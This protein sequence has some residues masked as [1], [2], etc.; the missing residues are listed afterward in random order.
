VLS[1]LTHGTLG[2]AADVLRAVKIG[3]GD[4]GGFVSALKEPGPGTAVV[5]TSD[6]APAVTDWV[7]LNQQGNTPPVI[8]R[9]TQILRL[10]TVLERRD[11][12]HPIL[13]GEPGVGKAAIVRGLAERVVNNRVPPRLANLQLLDVDLGALSAGARLRSDAETRLRTLV[14]THT[15]DAARMPVFVLRDLGRIL[16]GTPSQPNLADTLSSLLARGTLRLLGT[17]TPG[18]WQRVTTDHPML[19]EWLSPIAVE[20]PTVDEAI[21]MLQGSLQRFEVHHDVEITNAAAHA[22]VH[23]ASRY[24]SER[25]LPD[26]AFD[27]LDESAAAYRVSLSQRG[28]LSAPGAV[29]VLD[30]NHVA[31]T[32]AAW[33]GI[34]V[35]RMLEAESAKLQL[36]AER[37]SARVIG[38]DRAVA[39]LTKAV[40]RSRVGLR[41]PKRPIGSFLFLGTSGVGKTELAKALAEFLFDDRNA[42]LRLDM[43]E[44]ME[45][46]MAQ[47]LV[48][49]PPGYADSEQGGFLTEAVRKR[50]YSV[51]LFDEVEKAHTDVFNL[52]LQ[53]LD[54]GRLTDGRGQTADFTNTVVIMTS[55]IGADRIVA[56]PPDT[57]SDPSLV[58]AMMNDVVDRLRQFF[59]PEFLNR[60]GEVVPFQ[61]LGKA[62]LLRIV[63]LQLQ[64]VNDL[65]KRRGITLQVSDDAKAELVERGYEPAL[66]ARPLQ[67]AIIREIQDP[68]AEAL[69]KHDQEA[70]GT[71]EVT[72]NGSQFEFSSPGILNR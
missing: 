28:E 44:F 59:R 40:R 38:Q 66:G 70:E 27:L 37:L 71:V 53:V 56:A 48:G 15:N 19:L 52:L 33:T 50:P 3:P 46:H 36:M 29:P 30:E 51:L 20:P 12:C 13:I 8:G 57:F 34:P 16:G 49:S 5:Q 6:N 61:P 18:E 26:S 21:A 1:A 68:L 43:S 14:A 4:L 47:R 55:N 10:I 23:L 62:E 25:P 58:E 31:T 7:T 60:I 11:K 41:D 42:L 9:E 2:A 69:L 45:R 24:L 72:W 54:D 67:R 17:L 65:T 39:A 32:V 22:A 64:Q 35:A 63:E